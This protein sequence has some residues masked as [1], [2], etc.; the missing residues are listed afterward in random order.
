[1]IDF[2][3]KT[4]TI[5]NFVPKE[6]GSAE[7][8][9]CFKT[10]ISSAH[11]SSLIVSG[12]EG[13]MKADGTQTFVYIKNISK[14]LPPTFQKGGFFNADTKK[15]EFWTANTGDLVVYRE[16]HDS[17]PESFAEWK[18][19]KDKYKTSGGGVISSAPSLLKRYSEDSKPFFVN[20]LEFICGGV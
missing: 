3:D 8:G 6:Q 20:H 19:L 15:D 17:A 2:Y 7:F 1:M 16:A 14:Y 10:V 9:S 4:I 18:K 12:H 11:Y 5:F 13:V